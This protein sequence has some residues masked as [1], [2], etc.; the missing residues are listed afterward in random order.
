MANT[1]ILSVCFMLMLSRALSCSLPSSLTVRVPQ[2]IP[3]H[4]DIA[5]KFNPQHCRI[6]GFSL[7]DPSFNVNRRT[8]VIEAVSDVSVGHGGRNMS[9]WVFYKKAPG[10]L[11]S[12]NIEVVLVP[13]EVYKRDAPSEGLLRRSKR[14]WSPPPF[15]ILENQ[16]GPYNIEKIASDSE[17]KFD[18]Y[19]TISGPG[20]N[21]P[22]V[23]VFRLNPE[24]GMLTALKPVDRE[25][26]P[27]FTLTA[28]VFRKG[29]NEETDLP[30]DIQVFVDDVNDNSPTFT[31]PL[32]FQVLEQSKAGTDFGKVNATD[33]DE[34]GSLHVKIRYSLLSGLDLFSIHPETGV[35]STKISTL[36]RE[37]KDKYLVTVQIKDMDGADNGLSNT[38]TATIMVTDINDNPPEFTKTSY[39]VSVNENENEKLL[40]RIPVTD[41]DLINSPNWIS[42]FFITKGNENANF[43]I[44]TEGNDGLLYISKP[45]DYEKTKIQQLEIEARNVAEL[46]GTQATWASIPVH[47]AVT[48][49][50]EGPEFTAPTVFFTVKENEPNGTTIGRYTAVD[51]E[52]KSSDGIKYYKHIDRASWISV[53]KNSGELKVANTIDRESPFVQGGVYNITV[54]AVDASSKTGTGTVVIQ[55]ED[56]NDNVPVIPTRDLLLCEKQG[57]QGSVMVV[58]EDKDQSPFSAPFIFAL[59]PG[60]DEKWTVKKHNDTAAA[61]QQVK[62]LHTGVHE[63]TLLVTDLQGMGKEQTVK[64][65]VCHCRNDVCLAKDLS[66][67]LGPMGILALLLPLLLLL[68]LF[69]LLAFVCGMKRDKAQ[70]EDFAD[71]GGILLKSNT[72]APGEEVDSNLIIV[73][74][75]ALDVP[76][77]KG[78]VSAKGAG[79]DADQL[80]LK[81][82]DLARHGTQSGTYRFSDMQNEWSGQYD[83]SLY[84]TG[85]YNVRHFGA[86][87][88]AADNRNLLQDQSFHHTWQT[89]G[90]YLHQKLVYLGTEEDGRYADDVLHSYG[91]EGVGS[92]AG[93]VGCCSDFGNN[94]N[95]EFLNTLGPKFK[96]LAEV[97]KKT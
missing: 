78:S 74:T 36:D 18:V 30:L 34:A 53:D 61:L 9:L 60:H 73:P 44:D 28:R 11:L 95:L 23:G 65:R 50:D 92:V 88:M 63:V 12:S 40:L 56:V 57:E 59:P 3:K 19:Y 72:E 86:T 67:S 91:F 21:R 22:P 62:E 38:A 75:T 17:A 51:P 76:G 31:D 4:Y 32:K 79:L 46:S 15:N 49:V 85:Q 37:V 39:D 25:E 27:V 87:G 81:S 29:T 47:V 35:L 10:V 7:N 84:A 69:L 64:V 45:L 42:K 54:K 16:P 96:T 41:K 71:S 5:P 33:R 97:C 8:G 55:V 2:M 26:F 1:L 90:R 70:L 48:D 24:D 20:Y 77:T 80:G 83:S 66:V 14:R 89:N 6:F 58:A 93:S 43:R 82:R 13:K 94:D 52:T 68:L